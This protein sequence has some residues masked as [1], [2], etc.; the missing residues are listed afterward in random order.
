MNQLSQNNK[1]KLK[2]EFLNEITERGFVY[3]NIDIENL[4]KLM[5]KKKIWICKGFSNSL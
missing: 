4:D 1:M 2:S 5:T 3:Q